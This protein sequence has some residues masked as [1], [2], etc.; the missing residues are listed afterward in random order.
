MIDSQAAHGAVAVRANNYPPFRRSPRHA[1]FA[2]TSDDSLDWVGLLHTLWRRKLFLLAFVLIVLG[3]TVVHVSRL[4][5][6]YEAEP[7]SC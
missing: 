7:W 3:L 1:A 5:P 2:P 6:G 4:P